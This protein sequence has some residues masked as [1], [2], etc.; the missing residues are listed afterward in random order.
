MLRETMHWMRSRLQGWKE[1]PAGRLTEIGVNSIP[2]PTVKHLHHLRYPKHSTLTRMVDIV[3]KC[4]FIIGKVSI[5]HNVVHCS[6]VHCITLLGLRYT[7]INFIGNAVESC[8]KAHCLL[9]LLTNSFSRIAQSW[10][11]L[12]A[13]FCL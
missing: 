2:Q 7:I 1:S 9:L 10:G 3:V 4:S 6:A 8:T 12:C 11:I 13:G 5:I